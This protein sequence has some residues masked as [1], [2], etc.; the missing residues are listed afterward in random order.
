MA[1]S[2]GGTLSRHWSLSVQ[3]GKLPPKHNALGLALARDVIQIS[4][5]IS[6]SP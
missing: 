4:L 1:H 5:R 3:K 2:V 6:G